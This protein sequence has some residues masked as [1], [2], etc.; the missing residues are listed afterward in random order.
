MEHMLMEMTYVLGIMRGQLSPQYQ[1]IRSPPIAGVSAMPR[2]IRLGYQDENA[3]VE[4][5]QEQRDAS[6]R[7]HDEHLR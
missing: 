3:M 2:T 6:I 1:W 5:T 7:T 4:I